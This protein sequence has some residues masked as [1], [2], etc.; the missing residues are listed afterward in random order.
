MPTNRLDKLISPAMWWNVTDGN[1][2]QAIGIRTRL[3]CSGQT[4]TPMVWLN[5]CIDALAKRET[6]N[7]DSNNDEIGAITFDNILRS[8]CTCLIL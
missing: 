3:A 5:E 8:I 7:P 4:A 6:D 1:M 2:Y